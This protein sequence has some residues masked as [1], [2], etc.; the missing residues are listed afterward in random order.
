M[1]AAR[2]WSEGGRHVPLT[3]GPRFSMKA[4]LASSRSAVASGAAWVRRSKSKPWACSS[5]GAT[6]TAGAMGPTRAQETLL[7]ALIHYVFVRREPRIGPCEAKRRA[8]SG[9]IFFQIAPNRPK[10]KVSEHAVVKSL[11]PSCGSRGPGDPVLGCRRRRGPRGR[12]RDRGPP[13]TAPGPPGRPPDRPP[14][15]PP[16]SRRRRFETV[17]TSPRGA[18]R[19]APISEHF[20]EGVE[21]LYLSP[22]HRRKRFSSG[23]MSL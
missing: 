23:R 18:A 7:F 14:G 22:R 2:R 19:E 10:K 16:G 5:G 1:A 3:S 8:H 17:G 4:R 9:L 21:P 11:P 15:L 12:R 6:R 13:R 20:F